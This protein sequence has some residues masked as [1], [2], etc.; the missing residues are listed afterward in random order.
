MNEQAKQYEAVERALTTDGPA[1]PV[2]SDYFPLGNTSCQFDAVG[3]DK[4]GRLWAWNP[5]TKLLTMIFDTRDVQKWRR[6]K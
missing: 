2:R 4:F 3:V 5:H 1:E 6:T